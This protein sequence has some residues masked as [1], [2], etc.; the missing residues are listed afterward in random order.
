MNS[1]QASRKRPTFAFFDNPTF[2]DHPSSFDDT[3]PVVYCTSDVQRLQATARQAISASSSSSSSSASSSA[4]EPE[5]LGD[6]WFGDDFDVAPISF[7]LPVQTADKGIDVRAI[8]PVPHHH[9]ACHELNL[10]VKTVSGRGLRPW[11]NTI[12]V[13]TCESFFA[14]GWAYVLHYFVQAL[15]STNPPP[16]LVWYV[17][18]AWTNVLRQTF[19]RILAYLVHGHHKLTLMIVH[20][21]IDPETMAS[22]FDV[23]MREMQADSES[24]W[25]VATALVRAGIPLSPLTMMRKWGKEQTEEAR[26]DIMDRFRSKYQDRLKKE[27]DK[28]RAGKEVCLSLSQEA[29]QILAEFVA[30]DKGVALDFDV[31]LTSSADEAGFTTDATTSAGEERTPQGALMAIPSKR[32]ARRGKRGAITPPPTKKAKGDDV[33]DSPAKHTRSRDAMESRVRTGYKRPRAKR[34]L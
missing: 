1:I 4:L 30:E 22:M 19:F 15:T 28:A 34:S 6:T 29:D 33:E 5:S 23:T 3:H 11:P 26:R 12:R 10:V 13:D 17:H 24:E 2:L 14:L 7:L 9:M 8:A 32:G 16:V 31:A 25:G 18:N 21:A 27:V 20:P